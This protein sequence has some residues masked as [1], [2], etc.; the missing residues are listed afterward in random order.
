MELSTKEKILNT[1]LICFAE[2]GY[3]GTN[4][5]DFAARLGMSKSALYRHYAS[6]E[7]IWKALVDQIG[8]YYNAKVN[9]IVQGRPVPRGLEEFIRM[10]MEMVDFTIRDEQIVLARKVLMAEQFHDEHARNLDAEYVMAETRRSFAQIFRKMIGEGLLH[11][12]NPDMMALAFC[13]PITQ[14]VHYSDLRPDQK[15][16]IKKEIEEYVHHFLQVYGNRP[17]ES[18]D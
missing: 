14:L 16:E 2:N 13:A 7:E 9:E 1:A 12:G 4:L 17:E 18:E 15:L 6:K 10:V 5:R 3:R 8:K 11:R